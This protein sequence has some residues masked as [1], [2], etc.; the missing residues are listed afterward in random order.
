MSVL[1]DK[2]IFAPEDLGKP[3]PKCAHAVSVCLPRWEDNIGYEAG[4]PRVVEMMQSGY[5]RF[6]VHPVVSR[7]FGE[8]EAHFAAAEECC[9]ALPSRRAA[10]R[11]VEFIRQQS[12]EQ[13]RIQEFDA[14]GVCV[15]CLPKAARAIATDYWQHTGEIISSRLAAALLA[16]QTTSDPA[17]EEKRVIRERI[18]AQTKSDP[19]D[20]YLYPNGMA[21]VFAAYRIFQRLRPGLPSIQ[22]GFPYVDILKIQQKFSDVAPSAAADAASAEGS[23]PAGSGVHFFPEG[24]EADLER[25]KQVAEA[26]EIMALFCEIPGNPLLTSP[27]LVQLDRLARAHSFPMLVDDT[28]GAFVNINALPVADVLATSLTKF[29]S[30]RCDVMGGSLLLNPARPF[31]AQLKAVLEEEYE[32]L[33]YAEDAVVLEENS[34]DFVQ[35]VKR[36]NRTTETVCDALSQHPAVARVD[37]PKYRSVEN[38]RAFL[39]PGG[40]NGGLFSIQLHE[41]A[42]NAPEFYDALELSKGPNLGTNFTLCC[43]YTILAHYHELDFVERCGVS[44]FLVRVSIGLEDPDWLIARFRDALDRATSR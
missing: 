3:I 7:L 14:S 32:D 27:D 8:C 16:G 20:V 21:A 24:G 43:P 30:G 29:F 18:A 4:D 33:F 36:I 22:F 42:R 13:C 9:M 31:Y 39:Q 34:R 15:V 19:E 26:E 5:P 37:Y 25:T 44:R 17:V 23:T 12:Q 38:Y 10:E 40:G 28:L 11:C 1:P 2:P 41:P 35:R 6:F